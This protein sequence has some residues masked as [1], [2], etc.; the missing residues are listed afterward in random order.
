MQCLFHYLTT[1][2]KYIDILH[3]VVGAPSFHK[4]GNYAEN[5]EASIEDLK[6]YNLEYISDKAQN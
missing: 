2:I 4:N 1:T 6:D 3:Q 5:S